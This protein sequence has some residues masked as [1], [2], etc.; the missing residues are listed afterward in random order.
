MHYNIIKPQCKNA[1]KGLQNCRI[2]SNTGVRNFLLFP[3]IYIIVRKY[4]IH[5]KGGTKDGV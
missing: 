5:R 3:M 1:T 2:M 4:A